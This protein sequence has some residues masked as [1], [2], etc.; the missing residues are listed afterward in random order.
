MPYDALKHK[1]DTRM[2]LREFVFYL[3]FTFVND[4]RSYSFVRSYLC[5]DLAKVNMMICSR[6]TFTHLQACSSA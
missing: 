1:W 5:Y 6:I 4:L 2:T 3:T